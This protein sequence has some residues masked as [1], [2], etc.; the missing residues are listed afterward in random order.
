MATATPA[1]PP[2]PV[3]PPEATNAQLRALVDSLPLLLW[4]ARPD[5]YVDSCNRRWCEYTGLSR[6]QSMGDGW[7]AALHPD[8]VAST[9]A[10]VVQAFEQGRPYEVE[11]R[12]RRHD[13]QYRWFL[14]RGTPVRDERGEVVHWGGA[15]LDIQARKEAE[16]QLRES[17]QFDQARLAVESK[18]RR[19]FENLQAGVVVHAP[20]TS[21]TI[22]NAA[23]C[24]LLGLTLDQLRG[25]VAVDPAWRFVREDG[26][27]MPLAE[28]PV[29]QVVATGAAVVGQW[30]GI[31]RP[32]T[33][34]RAWVLANAYPEHDDAG[35][36]NAIVVT[37][38]DVTERKRAEDARVESELRL[39]LA[40]QAGRMGVWDWDLRTNSMVWDD[41]MLRLYGLTRAQFPGGTEAWKQGL[42]PDDRARATAESQAALDGTRA[43]DTEFR[44]LQ[45][46]GE[47]VHVKAE[48]LVLR[49]GSGAPVRMLGLN[50]DITERTRAEEEKA[51]L[52]AQLRQ[53]QKMESV[54]RLAGGVAHE[55]NNM[56]GVILGHVELALEDLDPTVPLRSDLEEVQKAAL[57]SA[58]LTRQL[59]S[60]ARK[61]LISPR[62]LDLNESL[63]GMLKMLQRLIG[64]NIELRWRPGADL[65]PVL[66]DPTQLH[67]VLTNLC[68]N[69]RDAISGVGKLTIE[70][71]T[72]GE[73]A[74]PLA[75]YAGVVRGEFVTLAVSDD[76]CGM[77]PETLAHLF[78]PFFTTKELGK[79][80]GLGL[81]MV[82]G[83]IQQNGGFVDVRSEPGRGTTFTIYLPRHTGEAKLAASKG[84][85][86]LLRGHETLLVVEDEPAL[87]QM[88]QRALARLGY[89]VLGAS[90]P[91]EALRAARAHAGAIDLLVTDMVMPEMN[92]QDLAAQLAVSF[93]G[94]RRVFMSGYTAS[95]VAHDGSLEEGVNFLQ[96]PFSARALAELVRA[97]LDRP[98]PKG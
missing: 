41:E 27:A 77:G 34:D 20:D 42:H 65:W 95:V 28:F 38:V 35:R 78:E 92:G 75:T 57:R 52:E 30:I 68:V 23:A 1:A 25:K 63:T 61:Q 83:A 4:T 96:K 26:G 31:D 51:R 39:K 94:L 47:V 16:E 44:V 55:F 3:A 7:A 85:E 11:Q 13:G 79:G 80:T 17:A 14:V 74:E 12:L 56:L 21:I 59:L 32:A 93:P 2:P 53:A 15:N 84:A 9:R 87:L 10:A 43:Y 62:V 73:G 6:E 48:G 58:E 5:G 49:D 72:R 89:T 18:Y 98:A 24:T 67:Q 88:T 36:L 40:L 82:H 46:G 22:A 54:G 71:G 19:L 76:G 50:R 45:P 91:S 69:A 90:G 8:D 70:T 66:A 86:P 37:F 60:F 81:A 97:V 29:N 33:G 64:E